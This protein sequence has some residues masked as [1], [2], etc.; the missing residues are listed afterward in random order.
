MASQRGTSGVAL[1]TFRSLVGGT[2]LKLSA[3]ALR[4]VVF[5][6]GGAGAAIETVGCQWRTAIMATIPC[7]KAVQGSDYPL[8]DL[9]ADLFL[10]GCCHCRQV[11]HCKPGRSGQ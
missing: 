11:S 1:V 10:D 5:P 8:E 4:T 9:P 2:S 3:D 6:R 7:L